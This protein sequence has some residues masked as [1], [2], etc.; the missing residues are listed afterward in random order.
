MELTLHPLLLFPSINLS[1]PV[2]SLVAISAIGVF[3]FCLPLNVYSRIATKSNPVA[4]GYAL[5]CCYVLSL[6]RVLIFSLTLH[7]TVVNFFSS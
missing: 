6:L 1:I 3:A 2:G 4:L 7:C 5:L